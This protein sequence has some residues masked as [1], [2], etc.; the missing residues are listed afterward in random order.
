[1]AIEDRRLRE[2]AARARLI[3]ATARVLAER[4]GWDAVTTRR[5][6]TEIEYSQ[7]VIYK[8][9]ASMEDLVEAVALEGFG[10]LAEALGEA[11]R[12]AAPGEAVGAAARAYSAYAT[13]NPAVYDAMFTR[14][15]RLRFGAEDTAAPLSAAYA[16]L[17]AAAAAIAGER[18]VDTLTEV[19]WATLHGLTTLSRNGRLRPRHGLDR[20]DLLVGA[21]S[22]PVPPAP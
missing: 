21:I 16:E 2:R 7:P 14:G 15:T 1:M 3:S 17:R 8:H 20:I 10:E 11:R 19:L 5:L 13:Q 18:D 6:S 22:A 9:F 12:H 4:E